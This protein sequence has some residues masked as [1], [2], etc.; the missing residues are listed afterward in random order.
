MYPPKNLLG[1]KLRLRASVK[2]WLFVIAV[3]MTFMQVG[4][5]VVT[6]LD[7]RHWEAM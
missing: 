6:S 2:R 3:T 7:K 5:T 1:L 4:R